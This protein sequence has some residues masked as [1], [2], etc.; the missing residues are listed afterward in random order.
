[1][2]ADEPTGNLDSR[3]AEAVMQL[4]EGLVAQDKTILMVTHDR[5]LSNRAGRIITLAD[6]EIVS[7]TTADRRPIRQAQDKPPTADTLMH[8][9]SVPT[10]SLSSQDGDAAEEELAQPEEDRHA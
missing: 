6:G 5:D 9:S 7:Q 2:V 10:S 8:S 1:L 4:F 3:T